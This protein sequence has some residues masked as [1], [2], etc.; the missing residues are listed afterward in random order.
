[1]K[2]FKK[3]IQLKI[4]KYIFIVLSP[5]ITWFTLISCSSRDTHKAWCPSKE[6]GSSCISI[7]ETDSMVMMTF[8]WNEGERSPTLSGIQMLDVQKWYC[9]RKSWTLKEVDLAGERSLTMHS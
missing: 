6:E 8:V 1:M 3:I 9:L 5:V 4:L 2:I 7:P